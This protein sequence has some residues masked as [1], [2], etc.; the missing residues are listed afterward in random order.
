MKKQNIENPLKLIYDSLVSTSKLN[1]S[2]LFVNP[3]DEVR[4]MAP[5]Y[6]KIIQNPMDISTMI[7]N[8]M[9]LIIISLP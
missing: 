2:K 7:V 3:V 4:D 1:N 6:Y 8:M 9:P 5:D